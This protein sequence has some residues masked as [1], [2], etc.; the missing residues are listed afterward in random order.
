MMLC[1]VQFFYYLWKMWSEAQEDDSAEDMEVEHIVKAIRSG[2]YNLRA[3]LFNLREYAE[4]AMKRKG[5]EQVMIHDLPEAQIRKTCKILAPFFALYDVNEDQKIDFN[6]FCCI[7]NDVHLNLDREC[8][9]KMFDKS[10]SNSNNYINFEEFVACLI[11]IALDSELGIP[12]E[13]DEKDRRRSIAVMSLTEGDDEEE[14]EEEDI[15]DD[16]AELPPDQQRRRILARSGWQLAFGTLLVLGFSDPMVDVLAEL[17]HRLEISPFYVSF[18]LAPMASNASELVAS[19]NQAR[20]RSSKSMTI[21]LSCL[22]GAGCMNN[23]FCLGIFLGVIY[24][25]NLAWKFTAETISIILVEIIVGVYAWRKQTM[26]LF[27]GF[28]ILCLY[29][30]SLGSVYFME[31]KLGID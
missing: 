26:T 14:E 8:Q 9:R 13:K 10:D 18:V 29:P 2:D 24:F 20:K 30:L 23:T 6:E 5:V 16:L 1:L 15:P 27:E 3:A 25:K 11:S 7:F 12:S 4:G 22:L 21:S 19:Y 17:G 28:C 31:Y